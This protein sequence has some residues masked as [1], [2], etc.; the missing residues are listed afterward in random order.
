[1]YNLAYVVCAVFM[2]S[3]LLIFVAHEVMHSGYSLM[4]V[5]S[6]HFTVSDIFIRCFL[7]RGI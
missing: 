3:F 5:A 4:S 6:H 7:C 2:Q 1:M